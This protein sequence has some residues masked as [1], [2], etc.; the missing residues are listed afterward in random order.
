MTTATLPAVPRVR[1][2]VEVGVGDSNEAPVGGLWQNDPPDGSV[3]TRWQDATDDGSTD[4]ATSHWVGEDP[5]FIPVECHV[6]EVS[7]F[8]GRERANE[9][10]EV[11][12]ATVVVDNVGGWADYPYTRDDDQ[13]LAMRP[14]RQIR[15]GVVVDDTTTHHLWGGYI[16][17]MAPGFDPEDGE[18]VT[19]ECIDAKGEAGRGFLGQ[20]AS[21]VG[22]GETASARATR[23]LTAAN[24]STARRDIQTNSVTLAATEFDGQVVD[25]LN[26][27]ADSSGGACFGDVNG[28]VAFR[29][30]DW[31]AVSVSATPAGTIANTG[32]DGA[33]CAVAWEQSF[34]REDISTRV[35]V[36][37]PDEVPYTVRDVAGFNLFGEEAFERTDLETLL[38]ANLHI[39]GDRILEVR[40]YTH[41]PRIAAVTLDA[42]ADGAWSDGT[43]ATGYWQPT[44]PTTPTLPAFVTRWSEGV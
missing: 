4:A 33:A 18:Y 34:N 6:R 25:L 2:V 8:C 3:V 41:M 28:K 17:G 42:A 21:P 40:S 24:W 35:V 16:D 44:E 13:L 27:A 43:A 29:Q 23:I 11:G 31:Q 30:R 37:R 12:T 22:A 7:T 1:P 19:L 9:T 36:G 10:W 20:L 15:V 38:D 14:G 5:L 32:E 26:L 39:I